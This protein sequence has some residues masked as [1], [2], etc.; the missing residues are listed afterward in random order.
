MRRI[1]RGLDPGLLALAHGPRD[2]YRDEFE[3]VLRRESVRPN[4]MWQSDHT[5]LDVMILDQAGKPARPWLTTIL[6]DH[7]RA[8]AGYTAFLGDPSAMQTALA[9]H[10]AIW[11]KN[12]PDWPV[13]GIPTTLYVDH[14]ADSPAPTSARCAP[15]CTSVSPTADGNAARYHPHGRP[16]H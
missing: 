3:L 10:Q 1:V 13:C 6:D 11:R 16:R 14:G 4:D 8:V 5:E 9:L 12:D 15:T 2:A 7:S